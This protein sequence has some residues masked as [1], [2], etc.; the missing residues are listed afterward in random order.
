MPA[1]Y[2]NRISSI[3]NGLGGINEFYDF[4]N[5]VEGTP[6]VAHTTGTGTVDQSALSNRSSLLYLDASI[7]DTAG[8]AMGVT[9][10]LIES[11][12]VLNMATDISIAGTSMGTSNFKFGNSNTKLVGTGTCEAYF[13][14]DKTVSNNW[15]VARR[16]PSGITQVVTSIALDTIGPPATGGSF[17]RLKIISDINRSLFYI[18]AVLVS[19]ISNVAWPA[20]SH[21]SPA[22][23]LTGGA[24][25]NLTM[26]M[27]YVSLYFQL[28]SVRLAP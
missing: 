6:F 24:T 22:C 16:N 19:T 28:P 3:A 27:D 21:T 7:G 4:L 8:F 11:N 12:E 23:Y 10:F 18:D 13:M 20:G 2:K 1:A 26:Y 9:A 5:G 14:A 25:P 15:I 17:H